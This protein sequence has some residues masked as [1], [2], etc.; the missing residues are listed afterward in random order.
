MAF[1][2]VHPTVLPSAG[3]QY[4]PSVTAF[5]EDPIYTIIR[6]TLIQPIIQEKGQTLNSDNQLL[7]CSGIGFTW[8]IAGTQK[9]LTHGH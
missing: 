1:G 2:Y 4:S 8:H 5:R 3:G 7:I 9:T 6:N